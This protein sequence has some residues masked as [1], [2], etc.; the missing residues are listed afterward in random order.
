MGR[1]LDRAAF[2]FYANGEIRPHPWPLPQPRAA[3]HYPSAKGSTGMNE[4]RE[5]QEI[6]HC[7]GQVIFTVSRDDSG[8]RRYQITW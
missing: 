8:R 1:P 4:T 2:F 7:G 5:F 3:R 6:A